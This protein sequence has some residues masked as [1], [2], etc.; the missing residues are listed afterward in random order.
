MPVT[1]RSLSRFCAIAALVAIAGCAT[2]PQPP[3]PK[4]VPPP[5]PEPQAA[6][7]LD[8]DL[9]SFLRLPGMADDVV[10]V[11]VGIILPFGSNSAATR[12]LEHCDPE[13]VLNVCLHLVA[14]CVAV[15]DLPLD[16]VE[17]VLH[18]MVN[19]VYRRALGKPTQH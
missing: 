9:P 15:H 4:P 7:P 18:A 12:A 11:R 14:E 13:T 8:R 6:N 5:I 2:K 1:V 17:A 3:A 10:P 16:E 19:D